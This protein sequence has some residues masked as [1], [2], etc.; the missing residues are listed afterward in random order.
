[1][2]QPVP[3]LSSGYF[4]SSLYILYFI[5]LELLIIIHFESFLYFIRCGLIIIHVI[6]MVTGSNLLPSWR[7][8]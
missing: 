3:A 8:S 2:V 5:K 6:I 4:E 1:M 7:V